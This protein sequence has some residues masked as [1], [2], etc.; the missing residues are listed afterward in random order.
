MII[1]V[2]HSVFLIVF[3]Y[4][5]AIFCLLLLSVYSFLKKKSVV[6]NRDSLYTQLIGCLVGI[7]VS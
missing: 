7:L 3:L 1:S 4:V 2:S 6:L 5:L